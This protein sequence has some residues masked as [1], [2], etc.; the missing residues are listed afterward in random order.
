MGLFIPTNK[1]DNLKLY[2]YSSEDHS[3]ISKY[4][5][6]RWWDYFVQIFP[7]SMA[8]NLVTLLGLFFILANLAVV[9]YYDPYLEGN[10]P[11]WALFFYAFGLFMYQT[12]DGCDGCH[13]RRTGQSSPLGELFDHCCDAVNTTFGAIIFGSVLG[14]GYGGLLMITQFGS[15]CNFYA[16]T[17]EEYHTHTLFLSQFSGPV[18][19]ILMIIAVYIITGIFG[20]EIWSI[21]LFNL[22]LNSIG[23]GYYRIDSSIIY[24]IIG[25]ASLYFNIHAAMTNVSKYYE[26]KFYDD[27]EKAK[28]EIDEAYRGLTPFFAYYG[29]IVTLAWIYPEVITTYGFPTVVSIGCTIAFSVGRIILS[30]LTLQEFPFIQF[31]MFVPLA[32]LV[33]SFIMINIYGF[34]SQ[35]TIFAITWL[36]FGITLGIHGLFIAEI[37]YD[38]TTYLDIYA[39]SIKH[40]KA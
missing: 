12:F 20:H 32:E 31:P 30:H 34:E 29:S 4:I 40:K 33:L 36:G 6:K 8:P 27:K 21:G 15:V 5:L 13:A 38:I 19:G 28:K 24:I 11:Q 9:F 37:I 22:N 25:L 7:M 3:I 16:S 39:L 23:L 2:K 35:L 18:E 17:W 14:M 10:N 1:L 26:K